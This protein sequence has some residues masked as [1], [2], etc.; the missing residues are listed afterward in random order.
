MGAISLPT[1]A[2]PRRASPV[3]MCDV[4]WSHLRDGTNALR[5]A[6]A[7]LREALIVE[8]LP[9]DIEDEVRRLVKAL[10]DQLNKRPIP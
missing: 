10:N 7:H 2:H 1:P 5:D 8:D 9:P 3:T 4:V 6:R